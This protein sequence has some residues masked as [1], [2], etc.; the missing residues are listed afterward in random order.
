MEKYW[1][2]ILLKWGLVSTIVGIEILSYV[3]MGPISLITLPLSIYMVVNI[4]KI[5][6]KK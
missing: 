5:E 2:R 4:I 1:Q 6:V 3:G